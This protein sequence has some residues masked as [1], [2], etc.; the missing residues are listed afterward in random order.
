[1]VY[2][3]FV[4]L[5]FII[6]YLIRYYDQKKI[7]KL[8]YDVYLLKSFNDKLVYSLYFN[9]SDIYNKL[10]DS[11]DE[12]IFTIDIY[13][14]NNDITK[15]ET[16]KSTDWIVIDKSGQV[17]NDKVYFESIGNFM[18]NYQFKGDSKFKSKT[19]ANHLMSEVIES[20]RLDLYDFM[21]INQLIPIKITGETI[22]VKN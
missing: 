14:K 3:I 21:K 18:V 7:N 17:K 12:Y 8:T 9:N 11:L 16:I 1:M 13:Y 15:I 20:F 19:L 2:K 6:L 4:L 5:S 10:T 22:K